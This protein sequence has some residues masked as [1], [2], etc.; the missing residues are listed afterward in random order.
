MIDTVYHRLTI[1]TISGASANY[2][3][4]QASSV[5]LV[6]RTAAIGALQPVADQAANG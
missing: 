3:Y 2:R 6:R 1:G 4:R 5:P